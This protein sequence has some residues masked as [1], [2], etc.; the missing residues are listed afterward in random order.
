MFLKCTFYPLIYDFF[1]ES[2][3][4]DQRHLKHTALRV[5]RVRQ[6]KTAQ[7]VFFVTR[8]H[9]IF[10]LCWW[11]LLLRTQASHRS[12]DDWHSEDRGVTTGLSLGGVVLNTW[13]NSWLDDVQ[14]IELAAGLSWFGRLEISCNTQVEFKADGSQFAVSFINTPCVTSQSFCGNPLFHRYEKMI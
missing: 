8:R 6:H 13:R 1:C 2:L 10:S 9:R 3:W 14:T 11:H 4:M 7:Q 5:A 12:I